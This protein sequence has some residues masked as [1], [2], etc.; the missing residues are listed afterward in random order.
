MSEEKNTNTES[1]NANTAEVKQEYAVDEVVPK[2]ARHY[3]FWDMV[4]TWLGANATPSSWYTGGVIA[5]LG[6][7]GG[8]TI[9]LVA[10]PIAYAVMALVGYM[11]YKVGT[12][13]MGLARASFGIRGSLMPTVLN[14]I[15]FVGWCSVNTYFAA[16]AMTF[17]FQSVFGTPA[18]GEEGYKP[19]MV[20]GVLICSAIQVL[21]VAVSGSHSIKIAERFAMVLLIGL[22]IWQTVILVQN[23]D[24][25]VLLTWTPPADI[26]IPFGKGMDIMVAFSFGWIP[27]ICDFTRYTKKKSG[28]TIA[29]MIGANVALFWFA[30]VG[31]IG[32]IVTASETGI[33]DPDASDPS[34]VM[35]ALGLGWAA[36]I[37]LV[38]A[39][40]TTNCV[41]IYAASMSINNIIPRAGARKTIIIVAIITIAGSLLPVASGSLV[42]YFMTFLEYIGMIFAPFLPILLIDFYVVKKRNYDWSQAAKVG[43]AYWYKNGFNP[44]AVIAWFAGMAFYFLANN[45]GFI[46]DTIGA[47]Y[48]TT[49]VTAIIYLVIVKICPETPAES[50]K[51]SQ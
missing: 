19:I 36:M 51:A 22:T 35:N 17:I 37:I 29:P 18:Y 15:Q 10:N 6:L 4:A 31:L 44:R 23:Y 46:M 13:T 39:T 28:A 47:I 12:S 49:I 45:T 7:A 34:S 21:I 50:I 42:Y 2:A 8:L 24:L 16:V 20:A 27:A 11:G 3:G 41:N 25:S 38:V 5:A 48:A 1:A 9:I 30:I 40:C 43:G 33:F 14:A 26:H 32:V